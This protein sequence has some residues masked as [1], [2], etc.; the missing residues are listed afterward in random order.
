MKRFSSLCILISLS[1]FFVIGCGSSGKMVK[2]PDTEQAPAQTSMPGP[3]SVTLLTQEQK[4]NYMIGTELG[5]NLKTFDLTF[6]MNI[7]RRGMEDVLDHKPLLLSDTELTD[8]KQQF[9][10]KAQEKQ[11]AEMKKSAGKN[12]EEGEHFLSVN[13][14]NPGVVTTASGLQYT[15]I[16][17]GTGARP[18]ATDKVKV[19]YVGT[20]LDGKEFDSSIRRGQPAEFPLNGVIPGWTEGLQLMKVGSKYKFF[21]PSNLA[22]GDSGA[23]QGGIGPGA[24]LI[25]EVTLLDIVKDRE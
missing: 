22:Y 25:F 21:I 19:H 15:V 6:D 2:N 13:K 18:K 5:K 17:E 4:I 8:V 7:V 14:S 20:L 9:S 12:A 24:V 1:L 3:E 11:M 23:P 16:E 10:R